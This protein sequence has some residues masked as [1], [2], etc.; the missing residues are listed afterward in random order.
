[1]E[2]FKILK[3]SK[4]LLAIGGVVMIV[5]AG[6]LLYSAAARE[7][8]LLNTAVV[9]VVYL[10]VVDNV[11][12][13]LIDHSIGR[14]HQTKAIAHRWIG[15]GAYTL[16]AIGAMFI[17][18]ARI[19]AVALHLQLIIQAIL[20]TIFLTYAA[21]EL[22]SEGVVSPRKRLEREMAMRRSV[23]LLRRNAHSLVESMYVNNVPGE[24]RRSA[25]QLR[26]ELRFITPGTLAEDAEIEN[27]MC[28]IFDDLAH[29]VSNYE[30]N[31]GYITQQLDLAHSL[32]SKRH[33]AV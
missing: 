7:I 33:T 22:R 19:P 8:S 4:W 23:Q 18:N 20:L 28:Q 21:Y 14:G 1:M 32:L 6:S 3:A 10:L 11:F 31:A 29:R 27:T 17:C 5:V 30:A 16:A 9:C 12:K 15:A 13:P 25:E 26:N 24:T 2:Q